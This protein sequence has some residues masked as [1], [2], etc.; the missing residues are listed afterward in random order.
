MIKAL[1]FAA[2]LALSASAPAFAQDMDAPSTDD[3]CSA[4]TDFSE[5]EEDLVED[6]ESSP[7]IQEL[8]AAAKAFGERM[9]GFETN[10]KTICADAALSDEAKEVRIAALWSQYEPEINAFAAVAARLGPQI[11][12]EALSQIDV[13]ALTSEAMAEVQNSGAMQGAMG[14][15]RNSA[16]TSGDPEHMET[17][18]LMASYALGE[19]MDEADADADEADDEDAPEAPPAA[20]AKPAPPHHAH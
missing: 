11:A 13:A 18:G 15:A 10:A 7:A 4:D 1:S 3:V 2:V 19:A 9:K 20:P 12:A 5:L 16:W 8:E 17:M 6:G 14:V